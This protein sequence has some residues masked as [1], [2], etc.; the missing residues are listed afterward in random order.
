MKGHFV[1][2]GDGLLMSADEDTRAFL[3]KFRIGGGVAAEITKARNIK[4]HRKFFALLRLAYDAWNAGD[5]VKNFDRFRQDIVILAG[6][7]DVVAD[8]GGGVTPVAKSIS[9]ASMEEAEFEK[10]YKAVLDVVW[11]K[12]LRH[13][14]YTSQREVEEI[15][16]QLLI[17]S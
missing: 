14:R 13:N 15:V 16:E 11:E 6:Y 9:F 12:I 10:V 3:E 8:I 1:K 7:Y 5:A 17:F 2:I 4:F